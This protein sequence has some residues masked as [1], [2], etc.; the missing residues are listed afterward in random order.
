MP[1]AA[2][3]DPK[4][5][6]ELDGMM[7]QLFGAALGGEGESAGSNPQMPDIG[8]MMQMFGAMGIDGE[9]K[10]PEIDDKQIQEAQK[11]F[12]NLIKDIDEEA[13][14]KDEAKPTGE[15]SKTSEQPSQQKSQNEKPKDDLGGLGDM[16]KDFERIAKE[17]EKGG[18]ASASQGQN[19]ANDPFAALLKGMGGLGEEGGKEGENPFDDA[20]MM[21]MFKGLIGSLGEN[22]DGAQGSSSGPSDD[23]MN[24]I[25]NEFTSFLKE[26]GGDNEF[27]GALD[28]VLKDIM[29]KDSMY[30]PMLKLKEAFPQWLEENWE[31]QTDEDLERYNGQLDKVTEICALYEEQDKAGDQDKNKDKIFD[32]MRELQELGQPPED[33]IKTLHNPE[34]AGEAEKST[35]PSTQ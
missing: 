16:F 24:N 11:M 19:P 23:Q 33:L 9:Q 3:V 14:K 12:E 18:G 29:N 22:P 7:Q 27:K 31:K 21:N 28:S 2:G 15:P 30:K 35:Q 26:Q 34:N 1:S 4:Q 6:N 25:M 10:P 5:M 13:G 20:Q 8:K 32:K 17:Q